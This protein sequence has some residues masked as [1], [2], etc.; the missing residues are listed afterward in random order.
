[1]GLQ[2]FTPSDSFWVTLIDETLNKS[3]SSVIILQ[4]WAVRN[5]SPKTLVCQLAFDRSS[6]KILLLRV[7]PLVPAHVTYIFKYWNRYDLQLILQYNWKTRIGFSNTLQ[8]ISHLYRM[9]QKDRDTWIFWK[10]LRLTKND[11]NKS[12][13]VLWEVCDGNLGFTISK[14][15]EGHFLSNLTVSKI[16]RCPDLS[17]TPCTTV[18]KTKVNFVIKWKISIYLSKSFSSPSK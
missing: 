11:S 8:Q 13:R 3:F 16:F 10:L 18:G 6:C 12:C 7:S 1:M 15:F 9:Y 2:I 4:N 5:L 17:G 14:L